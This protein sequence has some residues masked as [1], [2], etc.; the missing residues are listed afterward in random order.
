MPV[1]VVVRESASVPAS[2]RR[3]SPTFLPQVG[4][5]TCFSGRRFS[6]PLTFS[7]SHYC[8]ERFTCATNVGLV[9]ERFKET[10]HEQ[11]LPRYHDESPITVQI[12]K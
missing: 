11:V 2:P 12:Q 5:A 1:E 8:L 6:S 9:E 10:P 3:L 4:G 7:D